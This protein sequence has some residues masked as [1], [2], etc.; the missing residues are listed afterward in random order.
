LFEDKMELALRYLY[1]FTRDDY[2]INPLVRLKY[3]TNITVDVG[4][5]MVGGPSNSTLG[6]FDNNDEIYASFKYQF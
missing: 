5:E 4:V 6:V 1:N 2:Y 3:W